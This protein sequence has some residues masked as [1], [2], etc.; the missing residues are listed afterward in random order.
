MSGPSSSRNG[1]DTVVENKDGHTKN[2]TQNTDQEL[3][4]RAGGDQCTL[5]RRNRLIDYG[6]STADINKISNKVPDLDVMI[7]KITPVTSIQAA[8]I[9]AV[10]LVAIAGRPLVFKFNDILMVVLVGDSA[11]S[12]EKAYI[13]MT[14]K[15]LTPEY[16][17]NKKAEE[18]AFK[19]EMEAAFAQL[20]DFFK[21]WV[22]TGTY[23]REQNIE[24]ARDAVIVANY[25]SANS[26]FKDFENFPAEL[27]A[28]PLE[29]MSGVHSGNAL[30][31]IIVLAQ[32]Y[33]NQK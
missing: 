5:I 27:A 17:A 25:L 28:N 23:P 18:A 15:H 26:P 11:D 31:M 4:L 1:H 21:E 10:N 3:N 8:S 14:E 30:N 24:I 7:L 9:D 29:G 13:E 22:P 16:V 33:N 2:A 19:A 6:F 32:K 20:P 12:V